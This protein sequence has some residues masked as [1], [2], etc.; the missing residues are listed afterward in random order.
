[1][2]TNN[3]ELKT[4]EE[5]SGMTF[6]IPAYQRGYRW[7]EQQVTD[8]LND[9]Y[10]FNDRDNG[11]YCLQPLVV[12]QRAED[13]LRRIKE[14]ANSL[15]DV[16]AL[17]RGKWEVIDGQQR[18]TTIHIILTCLGVDRLYTIEYETRER[19][20]DFLN[21]I[22]DSRANDNIDYFHFVKAK[23]VIEKWIEN[24][25]QIDQRFEKSDFGK[26]LRETVKFIWYE[27]INENPIKVFT[28]LNIGKISL[29]NAELIKALFL[30]QS[31]FHGSTSLRQQQIA[32]EWDNIEYALQD[33]EMWLFLNEIG[34]ERPTRIDL[35]F[36]IIC[37]KDKLCLFSGKS[38]EQKEEL[39]TNIGTDNYK[40]FRYFY[41]YFRENNE[42]KINHCWS[43][44]K[45]IFTTFE[46]WFCD[47]ELYHY[48]GYLIANKVSVT[49]LLQDWDKAGMTKTKYIAKLKEKIKSKIEGCSTLDAQY[50]VAKDDGKEHYPSKRTCKP[51]LLLHNIQTIITQ[52]TNS[53][54]EYQ[55]QVFYKF[56]FHLYK[57]ENWDVEHIDS[58]TLNSLDKEPDRKEWLKYSLLDKT[59]SDDPELSNDIIEYLN[60]E[61]SAEEFDDLRMHIEAKVKNTDPLDENEKNQ[62]WN[63]ALLD[64]STNRGYGNAIFPVKRRCIIGKDQG[65]SF[66]VEIDGKQFSTKTV[67]SKSSFIPPCTKYAFLKYYNPVSAS[68]SYW[69]RNDAKAYRNNMLKTLEEF[70]VRINNCNHE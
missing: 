5:L 12:V 4:V 25:R 55:G 48:T 42:E 36:D 46:E 21:D 20:S 3:I 18:L 41:E 22:K 50:E 60:G 19:S 13:T 65:V 23:Q 68:I 69:D 52:A 30:N 10:E 32:M 11:F 2:S 7:T 31:N 53:K 37:D 27:A 67:K 66:V 61:K 54:K 62:I 16:E 6:L 39:K 14:E 49:E 26:K 58:N 15:K 29:T 17:L 35:I 70:D 1:M 33:E 34:Y 45:Q 44:V 38:T 47:L 63:F 8:L 43:V 57:L 64:E 40:T 59:I 24:K 51:L 56:P 9:I 28:R